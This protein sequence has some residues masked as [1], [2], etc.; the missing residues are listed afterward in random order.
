MAHENRTL[1]VLA[2]PSVWDDTY[3][4]DFVDIVSFQLD[5]AKL[6]HEH[7][8]VVIAADK[9]TMPYLDGRN[10]LMKK[11]LPYDALI[12][13]NLYDVNVHDYGPFGIKQFTK[14]VYR[15]AHYTDVV[16]KQVDDTMNRLLLENRIRLDKRE[17][18]L[19]LSAEDVVDNGVNKAI[20][21]E[22]VIE[23]NVE[24][25]QDWAIMI[26]LFNAFKK[27]LFLSHPMNNTNLRFDDLLSF[28]DDD[29][30]GVEWA[31]SSTSLQILV[32]PAL[33]PEARM[34]LE[35]EVYKKFRSEVMIVDLPWERSANEEGN[36]GIYTTLLATEKYVYVPVFGNDPSNWKYGYS[37]MMDKMVMHMLEANTR[38]RVVPV[39]IPRAICRRGLSLRSLAWT[40]RGLAA[41][42]IVSLPRRNFS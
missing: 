33:E 41:D 9:H 14:F 21:N 34:K 38:K 39:S 18:D 29:V 16:S 3:R 24:R 40:V 26:K 37:S 20:I 19:A 32:I 35:A 22:R 1:I 8:N 4:N 13:T 6:I 5:F 27:V 12:E 10:P 23:N 15:N 7:E 30:R 42:T 2:A 17:S 36:C 28:I 11:R 31:F 25:I